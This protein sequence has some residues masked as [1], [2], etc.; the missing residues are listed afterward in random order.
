MNLYKLT[1]F[2]SQELIVY[3]RAYSARKN[4]LNLV[5]ADW[6]N[7]V[8]KKIANSIRFRKN[9]GF[10]EYA[11][12]DYY[13]LKCIQFGNWMNY[14]ERADHFLALVEALGHLDKIIGTNN[15]GWMGQLSIAL[16]ARGRRGALAHYE[17]HMKVINL[18]KNKGGNSFAH[19]YGHAIDY[20]GGQYFAKSS[21]YFSISVAHNT[22]TIDD[23]AQIDE[24]RNL[25]NIVLDGVRSG[26]RYAKLVDWSIK[27]GRYDYWCN[28]TEIWARTFAQWVALQCK[29]KGI[30]DTLLCKTVDTGDLSNIPEK[31]LETLSP[32][33]AKLVKLCGMFLETGLKPP[34]PK[35]NNPFK[36]SVIEEPAKKAAAKSV[37]SKQAA[38]KKPAKKA[39]KK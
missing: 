27:K 28:N 13:Q 21:L 22:K 35:T 7:N 5:K 3:S 11:F 29:K 4:N 33:I 23:N 25:M 39:A 38:K 12:L 8:D 2:G 6:L 17:P 1:D 26:E 37:V 14:G 34:A 30:K 32:Y 16:G 10:D 15:I 36:K 31:E 9:Y 20:L 19:E 18:T 24:V